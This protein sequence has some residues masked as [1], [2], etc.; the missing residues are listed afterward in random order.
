MLYVFSIYSGDMGPKLALC[1]HQGPR[2]RTSLKPTSEFGLI[3][4][5]KVHL[6]W[7]ISRENKMDQI[8]YGDILE[9][10]NYM[11]GISW[12]CVALVLVQFA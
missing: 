9:Q 1:R 6:G 3:C 4:L 2:P 8:R 10:W 12:I 5:Y 7:K 11:L